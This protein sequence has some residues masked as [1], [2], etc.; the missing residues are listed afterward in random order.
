MKDFLGNELAIGDRVVFITP[1]Y[2]SL[3]FGEVLKFTKCYVSISQLNKSTSQYLRT[4]RQT[5]DQL[6]KVPKIK[7]K[8]SITIA[9]SDLKT[10][11]KFNYIRDLSSP[12][13]PGKWEDEHIRYINEC[14]IS[15]ALDDESSSFVFNEENV[16]FIINRLAPQ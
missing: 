6:I 14:I 1:G 11:A 3:G 4:L 15:G 2:R 12:N 7:S 5:P 13:P 9:V 8:K 16:D 10:L